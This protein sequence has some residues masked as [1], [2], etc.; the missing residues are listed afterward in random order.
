MSCAFV[1]RFLRLSERLQ[2]MKYYPLDVP[3]AKTAANF[4]AR[5]RQRYSQR[6]ESHIQ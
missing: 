5:T 2:I 3:S 6:G 4:D 1:R